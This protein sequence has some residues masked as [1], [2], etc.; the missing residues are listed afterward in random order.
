MDYWKK[1]NEASLPEKYFYSH[2]DMEDITDAN[3]SHEKSF[4]KIL[5]IVN[6]NC[7]YFEI[8]NFGEFV[9][10]KQWIIVN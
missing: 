8:K 9:S 4:L 3:Y 7:K 6:I 5:V 10:S 2:L 1:L